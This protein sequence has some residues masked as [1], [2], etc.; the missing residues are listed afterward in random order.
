VAGYP[1]Q[2]FRKPL[3]GLAVVHDR[4]GVVGRPE[5]RHPHPIFRSENDSVR[6]QPGLPPVGPQASHSD[7]HPANRSDV[8]NAQLARLGRV[9]N[10]LVGKGP[11]PHAGAVDD[12][13]V[14]DSTRR[15]ITPAKK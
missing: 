1:L 5:L 15:L 14:R 4:L 9:N 13:S 10:V 7:L 12:G 2:H 8:V 6:H 11:D 3:H